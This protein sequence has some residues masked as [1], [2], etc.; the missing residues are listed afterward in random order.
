M[1][2]AEP[3]VVGV[4]GC[5]NIFGAYAR[6]L[7]RLDNLRLAACADVA[8]PRAATAAD[9]YGIRAMK[10]DELLADPAINIVVNLTP[11][12]FHA[13]VSSAALAAGK[14]VY[15]EKPLAAT[16]ADAVALVVQA[17]DAQLVL[18]SAPDTFLGAAGQT[19]RAA[20]D[21][22]Q[23]GEIVGAAAFVTHSHA[24]M[25][26]PD[27]TFLFT[28]GGG[29]S[30]DMGPYYIASLVN[31][32]GPV[33]SVFSQSRVGA[34][35]RP[36]HTPG[37]TVEEIRVEIPT[38]CSAVLTFESGTIGTVMMSF[39]VWNHELPHIELYGTLGTLS[40]P[41]PD[42]YDDQV[43]LRW[44]ADEEWRPLEHA[45]PPLTAGMPDDEL[46]LR[47]P[48]VSDLAAA[49]SGQPQRCSAEFALH[50][51]EVLETIAIGDGTLHQMTTTCVR[52]DPAK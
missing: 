18:G 6:G 40:V 27:P 4:I 24:E 49:L 41:D 31:L 52:P 17:S 22:G 15:T 12:L 37:R 14:H 5:G 3:A 39:D 1:S 30:L 47:G 46:P 13:Q 36:V 28:P 8:G 7:G 35:I 20:V 21:S 25:W 29:P 16:F 2:H 26:H 19:A 32:L 44:H 11:P 10:V 38:H 43:R 23:L 50:V 51:L 48:G 9:R 45:I 42:R 34:A 33:S